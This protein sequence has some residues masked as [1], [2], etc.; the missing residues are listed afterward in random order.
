MDST[1][2]SRIGAWIGRF[3][4]SSVNLAVPATCLSCDQLVAVP[5]GVCPRCWPDLR[6]I[7]KPHCPVMGTPFQYDMGDEFLCV[8]AIANPPPFARLRAVM[9]YDGT[10]RR[11]VSLLKY[12]D[13]LDLV[14][15]LSSWMKIAGRELLC[16]ADLVI[17]V[18]LHPSRLRMRRF[19]QSAELA[20]HIAK[21]ANIAYRPDVLVRR[22]PTRQQVGLT[23]AERKRNV[24]GAFAVDHM[25][26]YLVENRSVL[27]I[28][29]VYTTGATTKAATRA[30]RRA[31]AASVDVLVFA[32]V[33]TF[34]L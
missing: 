15:A 6:F 34:E 33:E 31:G 12:G 16:N 21:N 24:A 14:P 13:R 10:A 32:K 8:E 17:P 1:P 20:R 27:L 11:L 19:N 25:N 5:G 2:L 23:E 4:A 3:A 7:R 18:P 28:D 9:L 30:L 22:K 29:D 26:R